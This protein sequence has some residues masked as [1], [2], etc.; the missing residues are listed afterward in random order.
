MRPNDIG[1]ILNEAIC[2]ACDPSELVP[3]DCFGKAS[4][5]KFLALRALRLLRPKIV[6]C[7][8]EVEERCPQQHPFLAIRDRVMEFQNDRCFTA[9]QPSSN[10]QTPRVGPGQSQSCLAA[11]ILEDVVPGRSRLHLEPPQ[12]EREVEGGPR[13]VVACKT[14]LINHL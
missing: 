10:V 12:M 3:N 8:G 11:R 6:T 4:A 2:R 1:P 14:A 13:P 9:R 5:I 7:W